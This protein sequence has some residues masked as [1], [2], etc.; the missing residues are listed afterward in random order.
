MHWANQLEQKRR[1]G[2]EQVPE[3]NRIWRHGPKGK[4]LRPI[5]LEAQLRAV[6]P[7]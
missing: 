6:W 1:A 5:F 4:T 2:T 7:G 3:G